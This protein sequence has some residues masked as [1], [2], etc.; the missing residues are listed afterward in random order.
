MSDTR[1]SALLYTQ[2]LR[3]SHFGPLSLYLHA[4]ECLAVSGPSGAGKT[5]LLRALADMDP[6][7]GEVRLQGRLREDIA[8]PQWR[9]SVAL[10]SAE[11][12]WWADE[13]GAH[14]PADCDPPFAQLGFEEDVRRWQV[15]RLSSGE[16]QRLALLRV[17]CARP[18]VLLLDEP[19]ANL[20]AKNTARVEALV[21]DY[22]QREQAGVCW[23]SH[24]AAQ[25]ERIADRQLIIEARRAS[26]AAA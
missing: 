3:S 7:E 23:V 26:E 12:A 15:A 11:P 13:V 4:G 16:R 17:L 19:T 6:N 20:D 24:D 2:E 5:L 1:S 18:R 8:P 9:A 14:F 25:R 22:K 10:L 21:E